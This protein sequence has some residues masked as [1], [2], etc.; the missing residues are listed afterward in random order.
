[1]TNTGSSIVT[2]SMFLLLASTQLLSS[3]LGDDIE[4]AAERMYQWTRADTSLWGSMAEFCDVYPKRL[5]GT[6]NLERGIDWIIATMRQRGWDVTTQRVTVPNWKRG[7]EWLKMHGQLVKDMKMAGLGGSVN[8]G[9]GSVRAAVYV[10]KSFD[11]LKA[12]PDEAR[13]KI[14]VWNVDFTSYGE[15]VAYR[16]SGA[17]EAARYG[18]VASLVR[19]IGPF[20]MQTPHTGSMGYI[21]SLP[22]IPAAAITMEDAMLLQR[23][24]D[25]GVGTELELMME[26]HFEDDAV[27]RNVIIEVPGTS[28]PE[29]IVVMGGHIDSWDIGTG[30]MDDAGGCFVAWRA[31]EMI[32]DLDLKPKRTIRL[33]LWTNEENGT[34]GAQAYADSTKNEHHVVGIECDGGTFRPRGFSGTMPPDMKQDLLDAFEHIELIGAS[35]IRDGEGGADTGPLLKKGIPVMEL[36]V[37]I[38]RYFWYHHTEADTPDKLNGQEMNDCTY[39]MAIA[40]WACANR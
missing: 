2:I 1:M 26:S 28:H 14:V 23:M 32:R 39:A 11:E 27:S 35:E 8:T 5:S 22:K 29:E 21:D 30:A 10:V 24:Q 15:T 31:L 13:G 20:G 18:A 34:R 17:S 19:S 37:D 3:D 4:D 7:N 40:A 33:C 25:R 16:Y 38:S 12:H 6:D 9:G 36:D